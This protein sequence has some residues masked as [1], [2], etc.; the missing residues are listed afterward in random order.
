MNTLGIE[1]LSQSVQVDGG[2]FKELHRIQ[3]ENNLTGGSEVGGKPGT[4]F[5]QVFEKAVSET[6]ELQVQADVAMKEMVAGRSKNIHETL[7]AVE[8]AD[9]SLKMMMQVRNKVLEAYKEIMR[10]QV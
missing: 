7:L 2:G 4:T 1:S 8:R 6:N 5:A 10:M 3:N 9:A